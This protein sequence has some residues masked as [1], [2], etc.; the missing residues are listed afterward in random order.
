[1]TFNIFQTILCSSEHI[2]VF[3][4]TEAWNCDVWSKSKSLLQEV[5]KIQFLRLAVIKMQ[6]I[7]QENRMLLNNCKTGE[8]ITNGFY[9]A[10]LAQNES[11]FP[12]N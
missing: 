8:L 11:D 2:T 6:F 7:E 5:R 9:Y 4:G 12:L 3:G 1:M 10:A